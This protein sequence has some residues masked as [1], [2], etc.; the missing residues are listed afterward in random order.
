MC[1]MDLILI[2]YMLVFVNRVPGLAI[3][4]HSHQERLSD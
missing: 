4:A 3:N 1:L 2:I